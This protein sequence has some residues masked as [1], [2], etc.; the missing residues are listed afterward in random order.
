MR[1]LCATDLLPKSDAAIERAG[2]MAEQLG[3]DLSLLHVVAPIESE[4]ALEQDLQRAITQVRSR[5][6]PPL[7][8]WG[9]APNTIVKTGSPASRIIET[10]DETDARL[11]ILGAH[12]KRPVR[13]ALSGTIAGK[14]LSSRTAPVLIVKRAPRA[15]YRK[16]LLALDLSETSALALRTS[17]PWLMSDETQAVIVHAH[18]PPYEGMLAYTGATYEAI[19]AYARG[20]ARAAENA[21]RDLLKRH[22]RDFTRYKIVLAQMHP[23]A[24]IRQAVD[25]FHPDLL[26]MG[27]RG[28]DRLRRALLGS[29]ANQVLNSAS[30]DVLIVPDGSVK[31]SEHRNRRPPMKRSRAVLNEV[32]PG[33]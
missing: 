20:R 6:K 9:R 5:S 31:A 15:A 18:E 27:T 29:V 28:H 26:V 30:S 19:G 17:E 4:R 21:V 8:Q 23:A 13:D 10:I 16:V 7:W 25:R 14:I 33:A 32:I 3:A 24:A 2:L 1:V 22:T 11:V 12:R